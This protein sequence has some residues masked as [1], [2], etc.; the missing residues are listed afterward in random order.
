MEGGFRDVEVAGVV[1]SDSLRIPEVLGNARH[2][3]GRGDSEDLP[4]L[5]PAAD[6]HA[7]IG[8]DGHMRAMVVPRW[9]TRELTKS[10]VTRQHEH[11]ANGVQQDDLCRGRGRHR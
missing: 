5:K 7:S 1:D 10:A 9:E 2:E 6:E 11:L 8:P 3:T 4:D